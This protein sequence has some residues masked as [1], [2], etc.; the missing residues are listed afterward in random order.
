MNKRPRFFTLLVFLGLLFSLF[1][2][3]VLAMEQT[4]TCQDNTIE[5]TALATE[6]PVSNT[7]DGET[8]AD[9]EDS[10]VVVSPGDITTPAPEVTATP[11]DA[12]GTD[13]DT[14]TGW[15]ISDSGVLTFLTSNDLPSY[16]AG[17]APWYNSQ[18]LITSVVI[19]EGV[20]S[21]GENAFYGCTNLTSVTIP[22]SV[23][24]IGIGAFQDCANLSAVTYGG[25][26]DQWNAMEIGTYNDALTSANIIG[27][28]G[29][30]HV[31]SSAVTL[32]TCDVRGYTTLTCRSCD[33][34]QIDDSS[35]TDAL[36]HYWNA[37]VITTQ[38]TGDSQGEITY[39]C[40]VCSDTGTE[41]ISILMGDANGDGQINATDLARLITHIINP[42]V[43]IIEA[44]M[45][46]TA[47]GSINIQDVVRLMRHLAGFSVAM[48]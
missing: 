11:S 24:T 22:A 23:T 1:T 28:D 3:T 5:E 41:P 19:P 27:S 14:N 2:V 12:G 31:Y 29:H 30:I 45:D 25:T 43:T 8:A 26:A 36:G 32:P 34:S 15:S 38:P 13:N 33:Y 47:D 18:A 35:Y 9:T 44:A 4:E 48:G 46:L 6:A 39:T 40:I 17:E 16:D 10:E 20:T 37:G 21:I 7:L 42:S